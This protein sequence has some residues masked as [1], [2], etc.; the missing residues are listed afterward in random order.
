MSPYQK[1]QEGYIIRDACAFDD[2]II[3]FKCKKYTMN[4][5]FMCMY[6]KMDTLTC[7]LFTCVAE[8]TAIIL[9]VVS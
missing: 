8:I 2:V 7:V 4:N 9:Q 1:T 6:I 3:I 5:I